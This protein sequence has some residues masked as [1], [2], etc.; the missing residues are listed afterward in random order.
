M[1]SETLSQANPHIRDSQKRSAIF[2]K[3]IIDSSAIELID[4]KRL[5]D[6]LPLNPNNLNQD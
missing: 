1:K 6:K 2:R 4:P 3:N 5:Q